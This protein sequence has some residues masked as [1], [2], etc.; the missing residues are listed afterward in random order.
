MIPMQ[1]VELVAKLACKI[2]K[3][4]LHLCEFIPPKEEQCS[5]G[6]AI[7]NMGPYVITLLNWKHTF[8]WYMARI[9]Y[10]KKTKNGHTNNKNKNK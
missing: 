2:M 9:I 5:C 4:S 8:E 10:S 7:N 6:R 1:L 3:V